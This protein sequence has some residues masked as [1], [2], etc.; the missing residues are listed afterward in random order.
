MPC[1]SIPDILDNIFDNQ[2]Q[3]RPWESTGGLGDDARVDDVIG[4]QIKR[5]TVVCLVRARKNMTNQKETVYHC[6]NYSEML[7]QFDVSS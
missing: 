1:Y 5:K 7:A 4:R 3:R 6:Y 2:W